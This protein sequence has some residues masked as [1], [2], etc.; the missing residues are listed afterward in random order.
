MKQNK[1]FI[2]YSFVFVLYLLL[3]SVCPFISYSF[4]FVLL[5]SPTPFCLSF[6]NIIL[7]SV[8]RLSPIS[9]CLSFHFRPTPFCSVCLFF[10]CSSSFMCVH[11]Y[12]LLGSVC[13]VHCPSS[14]S[15]LSVCLSSL[16]PVVFKFVNPHDLHRPRVPRHVSGWQ[17]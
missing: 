1:F 4:L 17:S 14:S 5:L 10:L 6:L 9:F 11:F 3:L 13:Y 12:A 15:C 8:C 7:H 16:K 2:A